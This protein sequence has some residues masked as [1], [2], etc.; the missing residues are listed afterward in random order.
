VSE[1]ADQVIA[2][3]RSG[4]DELE[5]YVQGLDET[6]LAGPSGAREWDVSHVLSHLG[7]GAE[8]GLA[9]LQAAL[10]GSDRPSMEAIRAV[11]ARWNALGSLEHRD[12]FLTANR[13]LVE[14]FEALDEQARDHLRIDMG[15]LPAPVNVAEAARLRLT[16]F[17]YHTWDA[18]VGADAATTLAPRAVPLLLEQVA[19][20]VRFA[21]RVDSL[22]GRRARLA[23][24][25]SN[26][27]RSF[28]L[29]LD[30]T[31]SVTEPPEAPDGTLRATAEA[32]LRLVAGRLSPVWTPLGTVVTGPISLDDL[33]RVFPGY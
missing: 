6:A 9:T 26:P 10:S 22:E 8:I 29:A 28:G 31:V 32:W 16:E 23:V 11:W 5:E 21:G 12:G 20:T 30:E 15:F 7:S 19:W 2:A 27:D 17:T 3:L 24:E 33:R 1:L 25:V 14:G 13:R 4:H 18:K